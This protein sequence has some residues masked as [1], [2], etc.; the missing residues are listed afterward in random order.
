MVCERGEEGAKKPMTLNKRA[1][2]FTGDK[3]E[4][5]HLRKS[6]HTEL[7]ARWA[8]WWTQVVSVKLITS[9][10]IWEQN[11]YVLS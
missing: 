11:P 9:L 8:L 4:I 2:R 3:N 5:M 6:N 1:L 7:K 10:T